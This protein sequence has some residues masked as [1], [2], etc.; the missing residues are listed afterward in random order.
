MHNFDYLIIGGGFYGSYLASVLGKNKKVLLIDKNIS[1]NDEFYCSMVYNLMKEDCLKIGIF[2][3]EK[4]LQWG[5]PKDLEEYL[6][7]S[8]YFL[9]RKPEFNKEFVDK[10][11]ADFDNLSIY[12]R[13][14]INEV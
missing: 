12:L 3:I 6:V 9:N 4:M 11:E 5:T 1:T 7:W 10:Y 2:E 8:N 14:K 13:R